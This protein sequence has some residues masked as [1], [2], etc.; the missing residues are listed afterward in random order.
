MLEKSLQEDLPQAQL[1]QGRHPPVK[2]VILEK[3]LRKEGWSMTQSRMG[4]FTEEFINT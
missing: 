3:M 2:S 4:A 1:P